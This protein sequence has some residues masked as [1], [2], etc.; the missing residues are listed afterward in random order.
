MYIYISNLVSNISFFE[1][2]DV[3]CFQGNAHDSFDDGHGETVNQSCLKKKTLT[4][5]VAP[6]TKAISLVEHMDVSKNSGNH[7]F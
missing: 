1:N 7:P 2:Y 4:L 5:V 3:P 6:R